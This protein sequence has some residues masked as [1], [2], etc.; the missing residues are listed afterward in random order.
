MQNGLRKKLY[1]IDAL[2][3]AGKTRAIVHEAHKWVLRGAKVLIVQPTKLL[4]DRTVADEL[5]QLSPI[6]YRVIHGDTDTDVI[7]KIVRH[8]NQAGH[9]PELLFI[10]Q[11][12]F[13]ALPFFAKP[14][15]WIVILDEI[16]QIDD[17]DEFNLPDNPELLFPHIQVESVD[18]RYG[19]VN[20]NG[21]QGRAA[22]AKMAKNERKDDVFKLVSGFAARVL[23]GHWSVSVLETQFANLT[24]GPRDLRKL[25]AFS[26]RQPSCL[27][28]FA[29]VIIAGA[30][31]KDTL[32]Y[33]LWEAQGVE[34]KEWK[35][36]LR[37][38]THERGDLLTIKYVTEEPWSKAL[39]NRRTGRDSVQTVASYSR[40]AILAEI[41][42]QPFL[43]MGNT[44]V[45]DDFFGVPTATRLPNS[46]HGLNGFQGHHTTV[47]YSA[48][49]PTSP[50]FAFLADQGVD[51]E[52]V[53]TALY[54]QAVYQAA[55]R[56]SLRD[57]GD[58]TAKRVIVMDRA[59]ADWLAEKFPGSTVEALGGVPLAA[60]R[61]KAGRPSKHASDGD[62]KAAH[63]R[64]KLLAA[65]VEQEVIN[66]DA[67]TT[68]ATGI[69]VFMDR[70]ESEPFA[71]FDYE[72]HDAFI[73]DLRDLHSRTVDSKEAAGLLSPAFFDPGLSSD[74][75]RGIANVRHLRG[76]WLD[77]DGG[78][79]TR[80][81]FV[82]LFPGLRMVVWNTYS[83]TSEKPRWR[84]FIPTTEAMTLEVHRMILRQILSDLNRQ[85]YWSEEQLAKNSGIKRRR[86]HGFDLSKLNAASL[87]YL[88]CQAAD[89]LGSFFEDHSGGGRSALEP[90]K[91][92]R[93]AVRSG[94]ADGG[95]EASDSPSRDGMPDVPVAEGDDRCLDAVLASRK[96]AAIAEWTMANQQRGQGHRAFY[97]LALRL[98][99]AGL[100]LSEM[101]HVLEE[102][103]RWARSPADRRGEIAGIIRKFQGERTRRRRAV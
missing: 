87:F 17:H 22:L 70:F 25:Q 99:G 72:S 64:K 69:P 31:F 21:D 50:H 29:R 73:A 93:R 47:V 13:F 97:R 96:A 74:T 67:I 95:A 20:P 78:D 55:M 14:E 2:A 100:D 75:S 34:F 61:V 30:C 101:R 19:L 7:A 5:R 38:K 44:D 62:R 85:G 39:R 10:S 102:E 71:H 58:L 53:R 40:D 82:R 88:P 37:Y 26:L 41:G 49:N 56:S 45:A 42:N 12:A 18:G 4:I 51:G 91:W 98:R 81:D 16:P 36:D 35:V 77:N 80:L 48:L 52:E 15:R 90:V 68:E 84:A 79:L 27:A 11:A 32:L 60:L 54:R 3:G 8:L 43:W 46:P 83:S 63:R 103:A 1:Y 76:I 23:S 28:G 66:L 6:P 92:V 59:T 86:T 24:S 33:R 9:S 57:P 89:P 65:L 94:A